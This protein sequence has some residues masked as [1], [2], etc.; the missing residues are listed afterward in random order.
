LFAYILVLAAVIFLVVA[1]L[2]GYSIVRYRARPGDSDPRPTF[3]SRKLEIT[4][5]A[6]PVLLLLAV[7]VFTVRTMAFV[8]APRQPKQPPDIII[9][10]HQWWWEAIY[11]NGARATHEIHIPIGRRLLA[12]IRSADV[13]H[14][15]WVPQLARKIDAVPVHAAYIWLEADAP[16]AYQGA[17]S[18][19]CGMQHAWMRFLVIAEPQAQ[20]DAWVRHQAEPPRAPGA[21]LP[22]QGLRIY[23]EQCQDCHSRSRLPLDHIA[24]RRLLEGDLPNTEGNR[25]RWIREPQSIKPG[26]K[27]PDQ[28][29]ST[30]ELLAVS[31]YLG[32]LQ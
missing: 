31:A 22:A 6:I 14:D 16:G 28:H 13:I 23:Q 24:S 11:P 2:V 15:F 30:E 7:F 29:L 8:D 32:T 5:T 17:C 20:F 3:G 10:G 26:N 25:A 27:M 4:W 9:T 19:F 21:G 12:Q 1:V 18:E